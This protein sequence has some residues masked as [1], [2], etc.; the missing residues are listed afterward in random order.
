MRQWNSKVANS[1]VTSKFP[2]MPVNGMD[3]NTQ[4]QIG[5]VPSVAPMVIPVDNIIHLGDVTE[6]LR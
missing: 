3:W 5:K 4:A 6:I 2:S 1:G